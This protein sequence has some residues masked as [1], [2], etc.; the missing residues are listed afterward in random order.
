MAD[1]TKFGPW[2][3]LRAVPTRYIL[4][5]R[6]GAPARQGSGLAFWFHPLTVALAEVPVEDHEITTMFHART[7]DFQDVTV[8]AAV[9]FRFVDPAVAAGR[10]DF[11][12][13][14]N[15]GAWREQPIE[16]VY[17]LLNQLAQQHALGLLAGLPLEAALAQGVGAVRAAVTEGF[18]ADG[19][20]AEMGIAVVE[21]RVV[22]IRPEPELERALQTPTRE[23]VQQAADRATYERRALAVE[24]ERTIAEEELRSQIELA[25]Q[26][27]QL[28]ARR[29]ANERLRATEDAAAERIRV[30]AEAA[31][32]RIGGAAEA[33]RIRAVGAAK[34]EVDAAAIAAYAGV[35]PQ[36]LL[37][38]AARDLADG[39]PQIGTLNLGT[40]VLT[41]ALSRLAGTAAT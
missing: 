38:L 37:A 25:A 10:I 17:G 40:D 27:E 22:A 24:H 36:V 29:G 28:V 18:A 14:P 20:L 13:D 19:R 33:E 3:H 7:S 4:Q 9:T 15:T 1:I 8:Q 12:I 39:L 34:A 5:T 21:T 2:R 11:S 31:A 26:E 41:G 16:Q 35:D 6:R 32:E 30:E 23:Q